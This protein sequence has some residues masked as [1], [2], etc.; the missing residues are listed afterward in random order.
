MNAS[1]PVV[2]NI[3]GFGNNPNMAY[4]FAGRYDTS[5]S[6]FGFNNINQHPNHNNNHNNNNNTNNEASN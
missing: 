5:A 4:G 1:N 2:N 6:L 3:W